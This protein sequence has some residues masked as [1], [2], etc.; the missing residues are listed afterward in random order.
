MGGAGREGE[1]DTYLT[2]GG[3]ERRPIAAGF[4]LL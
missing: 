4:L 1:R 3:G 2:K